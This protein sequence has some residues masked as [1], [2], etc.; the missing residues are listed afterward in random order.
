MDKYA[1]ALASVALA[2]GAAA[3]LPEGWINTVATACFLF[4]GAAWF[5]SHLI[6][7]GR[8]R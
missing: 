3:Y 5:A 6:D 8:R 2:I 4:A 1:R 7:I